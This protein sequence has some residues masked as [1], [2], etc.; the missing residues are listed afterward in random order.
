MQRGLDVQATALRL[1]GFVVAGLTLLL[2][3]QALARLGDAGGRGR[4]RAP[5]ARLHQ[6]AVRRPRVRARHRRSASP[7]PSSRRSPRCC[8]SV[9]TPVGVGAAGGAASRA[10]RSTSRTSAS[11]WRRCSRS[12]ADPR[13]SS[14]R[15]WSSSLAA[16]ARGA[17]RSASRSGRACRRRAASR[18]ARR[19]PSAAGVRMALEPGRGR[20]SVPVRSTIISAI[21]GVAVIAGV[22]GF[23]ASLARLLHEPRL[24][25]WNWDI[26]IGDLFAPDLR[27]RP[28]RLA[29]LPR[30]RGGCG[31]RRS[32]A[33]RSGACSFD[34]LAIEPVKGTTSPT[35]VE[36]RAPTAPSEIMLGT[37]TL[38]D[39]GLAGRR[40]GAGRRSA[41]GRLDC[42][43]SD[44]ACSPSSRAPARLRRGR[45][46]DVRRHPAARARP[47]GR[48]RPRARPTR[49][50]RRGARRRAVAHVGSAIVYLPAKPSDLV[51]LGRVGGLPSIIAGLARDHGDRDARARAVL[52]GAS[53]APRARDPQGA[54]LPPPAG[55]GRD[56]VAGDGRRA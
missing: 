43:S 33:C 37:R 9:L 19:P 13:A 11:A 14:P 41:T 46:D 12:F 16:A 40:H 53:A 8:S 32:C 17:C 1:L 28:M 25:G 35:V 50:G 42:A 21:L 51:D 49:P 48:R 5:R 4:R 23:S 44:V 36:G 26:Q 29:A 3:G 20:S 10:S 38:E 30:D 47:G 34:T 2:L 56:R 24:Y 31:R 27:P 6:R 45:D 55:V 52:V 54:R 15:W 39:L 18:S 22:L 7:R